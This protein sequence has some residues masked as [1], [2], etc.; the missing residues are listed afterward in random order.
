VAGGDGADFCVGEQKTSCEPLEAGGDLTAGT[1]TFG[2][3]DPSVTLT[4]GDGWWSH[5]GLSYPDFVLIAQGAAVNGSAARFLS[6]NHVPDQVMDFETG[7]LVPLE[8]DFLDWLTSQDCI[9]LTAGPTP[10]TVAGASGTSVDFSVGTEPV[11]FER[12]FW[13]PG[14]WF[15]PGERDRMYVVDADGVDLIIDIATVDAAQFDAFLTEAEAVLDTVE[16]G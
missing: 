12:F 8:G 7:Q 3:F 1:Y 16:F 15:S 2:G 10:A 13:W 4:V 9:D 6:F 11:C 14:F 5:A